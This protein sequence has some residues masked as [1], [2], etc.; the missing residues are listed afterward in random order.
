MEKERV[1]Q[2]MVS[3]ISHGFVPTIPPG[4]FCPE[5]KR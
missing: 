5:P 2:T 1:V 4:E 3:S